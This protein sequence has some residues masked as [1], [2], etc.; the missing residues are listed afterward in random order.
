MAQSKLFGED[1]DNGSLGFKTANG[2]GI[3]IN[4]ETLN[5][6]KNKLFT[7]NI[8]PQVIYIS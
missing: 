8:E 5:L 6:M 2:A 4:K 3:A 1:S 7:N